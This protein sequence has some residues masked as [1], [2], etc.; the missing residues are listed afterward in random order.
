M[1]KTLAFPQVTAL[2]ALTPFERK[3]K[4]ARQLEANLAW[5]LSLPGGSGA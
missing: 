4:L 3:R 2:A 1:K 5:A